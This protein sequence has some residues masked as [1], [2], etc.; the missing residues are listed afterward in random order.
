MLRRRRPGP[1]YPQRLLK[2]R[3]SSGRTRR[4]LPRSLRRG[5]RTLRHGPLDPEGPAEPMRWPQGRSRCNNQPP[6]L[7]RCQLPTQYVHRLKCRPY[8][9]QL[10]A[11]GPSRPWKISGIVPASIT[12]QQWMPRSTY[13][14]RHALRIRDA[15]P[16]HLTGSVGVIPRR[17]ICFH[18]KIPLCCRLS[19][20][21]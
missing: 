12:V 4:A 2:C 5:Y 3:T 8:K 21:P 10:P 16:S 14:R 18:I 15:E 7:H 11:S 19:E 9:K 17:I 20:Q 13:L 1:G 6:R